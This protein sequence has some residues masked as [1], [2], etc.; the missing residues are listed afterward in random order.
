MDPNPL[1]LV[2]SLTGKAGHRDKHVNHPCEKKGRDKS[3]AP[4]GK[5]HQKLPEAWRQAWSIFSIMVLSRTNPTNNCKT[6][7]FCHFSHL[8]CGP[9]SQQP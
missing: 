3:D 4:A 6:I 9:L 2:S 5:E 7:N 8:V 1:R